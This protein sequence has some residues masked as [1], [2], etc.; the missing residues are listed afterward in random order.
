MPPPEPGQPCPQCGEIHVRRRPNGE[1][2]CQAHIKNETN[3]RK[4]KQCGQAAARGQQVC[5]YHGAGAP[6]NKKAGALRREAKRL[7]QAVVTFGLPR[8]IEPHIALLE[9]VAR[10]AGHVDWLGQI[11]AGLEEEDVI[12]GKHAEESGMGATGSFD[13]TVEQAGV[14]IWVDLYQRERKHLV[15]V[16]AKCI[17]LGIAERQVQ[18]AE[19]QGQLIGQVLRSIF[20]DPDLALTPQ[21]QEVAKSVAARH[22]RAMPAA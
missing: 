12:W 14:S 1:T 6:Q 20:G 3:G 15:D 18:L 4:G 22:L 8:D 16:C 19:Q 7:S 21:Q 10:T 5:R 13:K 2:R 11:V 9:E 17:A